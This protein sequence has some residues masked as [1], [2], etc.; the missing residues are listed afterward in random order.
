MTYHYQLYG[1]NIESNRELS[2][3]TSVLALPADL[4]VHWTTTPAESPDPKLQ[5]EPVLTPELQ[6]RRGIELFQAQTSQGSFRKL[7]YQT[8]KAQVEFL[9]APSQDKLWIIYS[10]ADSPM[11]LQSYF[12]GPALGCIL[13]WRGTICLHASVVKLEDQAIAIVGRKKAGKSTTATGLARMGASLVSD[14]LAVLVRNNGHI[15]VQP[16]YPQVR[17]WPTS[18]E[19]IYPGSAVL[20]K[21]FSHRDKR[22]LALGQNDAP[23]FWS[24]PLA[25]AGIYVLEPTE[26]SVAGPSVQPLSAQ[27]KLIT[28]V[29]NTFGSYVVTDELRQQEFSELAAL[30]KVIP[31]CRIV[32]ARDLTKLTTQSQAIIDDFRGRVASASQQRVALVEE[33]Q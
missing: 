32:F 17:L 21:V 22:Y 16:G 5:W 20:P 23:A 9:L 18:I 25:L 8:P 6:Q 12:V 28:L 10:E 11:D 33:C 24:S 31:L 29:A 19:A 14:D 27:E 4:I 1:L 15:L 26:D 3:L 30:S 2:L 13:R 7:R